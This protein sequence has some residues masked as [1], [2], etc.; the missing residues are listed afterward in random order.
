MLKALQK[1]EV[2]AHVCNPSTQEVE[3]RGSDVWSHPWLHGKLEASLGYLR[4]SQNYSKLKWR[5]WIMYFKGVDSRLYWKQWFSSQGTL[6]LL[7]NS[8]CWTEGKV[9]SWESPCGYKAQRCC[10]VLSPNQKRWYPRS[11]EKAVTRG[12]TLSSLFLT[13]GFKDPPMENE[14]LDWTGLLLSVLCWDSGNF[15]WCKQHSWL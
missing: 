13:V 4:L 9:T 5:I 14:S 11:Q 3:V 6:S 10:F 8:H 15:C 12:H 1:P 7:K 2:G